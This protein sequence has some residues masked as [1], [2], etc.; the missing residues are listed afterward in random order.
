MEGMIRAMGIRSLNKTQIGH[1]THSFLKAGIAICLVSC[2]ALLC[3]CS[4]PMGTHALSLKAFTSAEPIDSSPTNARHIPEAY[5]EP[6]STYTSYD[7]SNQIVRLT[8]R[9]TLY[10]TI[11]SAEVP[12]EVTYASTSDAVTLSVPHDIP[13]EEMISL[14]DAADNPVMGTLA[15]LQR[16]SASPTP[17][18]SVTVS[19][20][21]A[22]DSL[23]LIIE[24]EA[25]PEAIQSLYSDCFIGPK[26][27]LKSANPPKQAD[28]DAIPTIN[29]Q[30]AAL[31]LLHND[32]LTVTASYD[33][34]TNISKAYSIRAGQIADNSIKSFEISESA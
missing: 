15:W 30:L 4:T 6:S 16:A 13:A 21:D 34:G 33:D 9:Y 20:Q 11:D 5:L 14:S 1:R 25:T 18:E 3:A 24:I 29:Q 19:G 17:T 2:A 28:A 23:R 12:K 8:T 26:P 22:C 10:A 32:F 31:Y 7:D 27:S